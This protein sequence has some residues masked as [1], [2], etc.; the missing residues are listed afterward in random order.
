MTPPK[1]GVIEWL[2]P[3]EY[4]RT[5]R[6]LADLRRLGITRLRTGVSW[7]DWHTPGGDRWYDWLL[8]RLAREVEVLPCFHYTPP[9]LGLEP[10]TASPPRVP[11]AYADFLDVF[12]TRLGKH[13]Q[14]VELWNE[15]N[16]LSDWDW[17]L[18]PQWLI[19]CDMVSK[20][21][22]WMQQ[23]GKK[24]VLGGMCPTDPGWLDL[25][26]RQGVMAHIDALGLHGFP[27]TWEHD[28]R[29]WHQP[30]GKVRQVLDH[31]DLNPEIWITE[32]GYSTW[33]H[34]EIEQ[35]RALDELLRAPA[36][37]VYWYSGHDLHPD[38]CH[39]DGFHQDERHYHFGLYRFDGRPK[40][41]A[42]LWAKQGEAGV[43]ELTA[44]T[45]S[46]DA[47]LQ[48]RPQRRNEERPVLITGGAGFVGTN[49]AARLAGQGPVL[50]LD[51]LSRPGVEANLAWLLQRF[52][53]RL[54]VAI[55]DIRDPYLLRSAVREAGRI[56]HFAAQVAVTTSL[57]DPAEDFEINAQGTLNLL[58]AIRGL[59]DPPP[60]VFTSTNKVYGDLQ[61]LAMVA[62]ASRYRPT[63]S[64]IL[65]HGIG[66]TRPLDFHSPYGCSKGA[67]DQYVL[68][69]A[70]S[71]H[72][73]ALV[74]R[75]SCIYGPHQFGTEDQG[76]VA[77]FLIQALEGK[78]IT[79]Y[80]DGRQVRD[81]LFVEDL[82]EA[83][84]LA[85]D[86]MPTLKGQVFNI[87][88]GPTNAI[89]LLE[90]VEEIGRLQGQ[91]PAVDFDRWRTGDQKYYV[92]DIRR[93]AAATGWQPATDARQGVARLHRWL[94]HNRRGGHRPIE[95]IP[96]EVN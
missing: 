18:D 93:F 31:H 68:D 33:R 16:N 95:S 81:V 25:I 22:Y 91:A 3:G 44:I 36:Q 23:R 80:G 7:A 74:L 58:E 30:I 46:H 65:A 34:D 41:L 64:G 62:E 35:L 85:Q 59:D 38:Q 29:H 63:D 96:T 48:R 1:L 77:H 78:P 15:P 40:L 43:R 6:L 92:S 11:K 56:Y 79:L 20:A 60:L 5:E 19:F 24:T 53:D 9:S 55:A 51:N 37:R 76:W 13:F 72:L 4:Q 32:A 57:T 52:P 45:A 8:P 2:R 54:R 69:Y 70:R 27:G 26:C 10:R 42:R 89:S 90:L 12:V 67:A 94:K 17:R 66:E 50:I 71:F 47:G 73:P 86:H 14:W 83:M 88:G 61:D 75:M 84:I 21:G 39:Q 28:W 87:G 82:V 49:L